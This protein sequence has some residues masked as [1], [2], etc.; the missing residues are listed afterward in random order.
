MWSYW[1]A[2]PLHSTK[3]TPPSTRLAD[4]N[5]LHCVQECCDIPIPLKI[6]FS[7]LGCSNVTATGSKCLQQTPDC[8]A[9]PTAAPTF[10]IDDI[11]GS[12][13]ATCSGHTYHSSLPSAAGSSEKTPTPTRCGCG[14]GWGLHSVPHIISLHGNQNVYC[15]CR[16]I[17]HSQS[18][19]KKQIF[20]SYF[21]HQIETLTVKMAKSC[22][23]RYSILLLVLLPLSLSLAARPRSVEVATEPANS[24]LRGQ[25]G[26]QHHL[27]EDCHWK[28]SVQLS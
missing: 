9:T 14:S 23:S 21:S 18:I 3:R 8:V 25:E 12:T 1:S 19:A 17:L 28:G 5:I 24:W 4:S 22:S 11:V 2:M 6:L 16:I 20:G 15:E 10:K 7:L 26:V 13:A 27:H